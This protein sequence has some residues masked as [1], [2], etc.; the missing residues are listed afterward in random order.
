MAIVFSGHSGACE[1]RFHSQPSYPLGIKAIKEILNMQEIREYHTYK[2]F[3]RHL[4][5]DKLHPS[6][7][8]GHF[9]KRTDGE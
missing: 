7:D 2:P 3:L 9:G 1:T 6:K 5:E 8:W 4:P